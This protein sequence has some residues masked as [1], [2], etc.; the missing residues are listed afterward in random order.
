MVYQGNY[1]YLP[2]VA[3]LLLP[4]TT[5]RRC[6]SSHCCFLLQLL[7]PRVI[8]STKVWVN[9]G[10]EERKTP[11]P[12]LQYEVCS[13]YSLAYLC[14]LFMAQKS[15]IRHLM[16]IY[17]VSSHRVRRFRGKKKKKDKWHR[18]CSRESIN[19]E[20][21]HRSL[22]RELKISGCCSESIFVFLKKTLLHL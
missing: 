7:C 15:I 12:K 14:F 20:L 5:Q 22:K 3:C 8:N 9:L 21:S 13:V 18:F 17:Y 10:H 6:T 1:Q 16:R 19:R 2:T 11:V 4:C